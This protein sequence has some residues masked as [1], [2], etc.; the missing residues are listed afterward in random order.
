VEI[1]VVCEGRLWPRSIAPPPYT[2]QDRRAFQRYAQVGQ[3]GKG[4]DILVKVEGEDDREK[5]SG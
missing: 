4:E 5:T 3:R 1:N 2:D